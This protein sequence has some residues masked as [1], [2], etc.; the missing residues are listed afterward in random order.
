VNSASDLMFMPG[1]GE[2]TLEQS[3]R[4]AA[5]AFEQAD[6]TYGHGTDN[7]LDEAAWLIAH[8]RGLSPL[9]V[10]DYA[11][12]ISAHERGAIDA[13]VRQRIE[14]RTPAAYLTGRTWFAGHEFL[15]DARALVPR[16]PFAEF[17]AR[18]FFGML[19]G[20][21]EPRILD[22]CTGGGCIAI[23]AALARSDAHVDAS[24]L[25]ADALA[26]ARENVALHGLDERVH[27]LAGSVFDPIEERYDLI[28]SN[29]PYVDAADVAAMSDEF[30]HEPAMGLGA[31]DDGMDIVA[32]MLAEAASYLTDTGWL[33][34]EVGN[35][36]AA[37]EARW[38]EL[39]LVWLEFDGGGAGV[40]A[41]Q[42]SDLAGGLSGGLFWSPKSTAGEPLKLSTAR[43]VKVNSTA[44]R[45]R[46]LVSTPSS[47]SLASLNCFSM[48]VAPRIKRTRLLSIRRVA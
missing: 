16:S 10:P 36:A 29:P 34:V 31:G 48:M 13:L 2:L 22:L 3:I 39:E 43:G 9:D 47:P 45:G 15:C 46:T 41:V 7:A 27:L 18:D 33:V 44:G 19:D 23:S 6:L 32:P 37:V 28:M 21:S 25:S 30:R 42:R 40:F 38:P 26:L 20:K 8:A 14:S 24:D 5:T 12:L 4:L 11:E 17:I 1:T 35:S